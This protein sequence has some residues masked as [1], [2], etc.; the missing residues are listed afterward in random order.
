[1]DLVLIG[2]RGGT[3][4][5]GSFERA[6]GQLGVTA[7]MIEPR[8]AYDGPGWL[9]R[10]NWWLRGR[11]PTRLGRFDAELLAT[12]RRLRSPTVLS[13]GVS[14]PGKQVAMALRMGGVRLVNYLT[15]D[16]WQRPV[17]AAWFIQALPAY[18]AVYCTKREVVGDLRRAGAEQVEFLPFAYDPELHFVGVGDGAKLDEQGADVLFVGGGDRDRFPFLRALIKAGLKVVIHGS[19]WERD[20][21]TKTAWRGQVGPEQLRTS[22]RSARVCLC[23]V[24]RANRD[25]HVMRTFEIAAMGGCMLA[26]DTQEHREILGADGECAVF[27]RDE[28]ELVEKARWLLAHPEERSR[29]V[30][31]AHQR[32]TGGRNTYADRLRTMLE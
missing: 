5:G 26:E 2:N 1:M 3:N 8:K 16:P 32:I 19:Y 30:R 12:V 24:R 13:V 4:V 28:R 14:P 23:L 10:F 21:V 18:C 17:V 20:S 29:L 31:A 6:A 7:E 9:R 25:G 22:T 15:D 11:R 27:F